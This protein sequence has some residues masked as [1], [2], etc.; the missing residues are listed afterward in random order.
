MKLVYDLLSVTDE[1]SERSSAN[2]DKV[3][4]DMALYDGVVSNVILFLDTRGHPMITPLTHYAQ[5]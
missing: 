4:A 1:C 3:H 5:P 2:I